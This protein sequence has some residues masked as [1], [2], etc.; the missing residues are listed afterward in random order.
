MT[1]QVPCVVVEYF[2]KLIE[3][4]PVAQITAHKVRHFVWKSIVCC[5]GVPRRLVLDHGM[6]FASQQLDKLCSELGIKQIFASVEH[7]QTN[8]QVKSANRVLLRGLK[9]RLEKNKGA[10]AKEVPQILWA[11]HTT[12]QS[13]TKETSFSLVYETDAMIPVEIH[14]SSFC[15]QNFVTEEF[16]EGRRMNLDLLEEVREQAHIKSKALKRRV[17]LRQRTKVR[18]RQ[19]QVFDLV[20]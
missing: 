5:F 7:P 11:Y 20:M 17:E 12:P 16:D 18:P 8:G 9:K 15:F 3:V 10:W 6:Q 13:N 19:F 4:E 14:E 1:N 2:T